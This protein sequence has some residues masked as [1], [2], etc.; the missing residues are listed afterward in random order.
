MR[1]PDDRRLSLW[2]RESK[3]TFLFELLFLGVWSE[4]HRSLST[5]TSSI[6]SYGLCWRR[7][8]TSGDWRVLSRGLTPTASRRPIYQLLLAKGTSQLSSWPVICL[9][10]DYLCFENGEEEEGLLWWEEWEAAWSWQAGDLKPDREW[11]G[12]KEK[13]E[14]PWLCSS[15]LSTSNDHTVHGRSQARVVENLHWSLVWVINA[16]ATWQRKI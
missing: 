15:V 2:N 9:I 4:L 3:W 6:L 16:W 7:C 10:F 12:L 5:E 1:G 13:G 8:T 14:K 11:V